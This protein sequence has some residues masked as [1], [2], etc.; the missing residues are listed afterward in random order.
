VG[1]ATRYADGK[2]A[3]EIGPTHPYAVVR[4]LLRPTDV[5]LDVGCG[6]GDA[7]AYLAPGVAGV[8]GVEAD[9][10]RAAVARTRMGVVAEGLVRDGA[11]FAELR[12]SYDAVLLLDVVEHVADPGGLLRWCAAKLA[13]GGRILALVPNSSHASFRLAQLLGRWDYRDTGLFDRDHLRFYNVRTM[14][15]LAAHADLREVGRRYF[16]VQGGK[17]PRSPRLV[18][19]RPNLLAFSVLL[20]WSR[21]RDAAPA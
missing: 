16:G 12:T 5:V 17:W 7:A 19:L 3:A 13:P 20:V 1:E 15:A 9:P 18:A 2:S 6:S 4:T 10:A 14:P 21:S 8:D 11:E